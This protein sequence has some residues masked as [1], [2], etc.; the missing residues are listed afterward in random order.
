MRLLVLSDIHNN[1]ACVRKLRD[2]ETNRFDAVVIAGD[3]GSREA[4]KI[5]AVLETFACPVYYVFGNW[6]STLDYDRSF[7]P[8]AF[9]LHHRVFRQ[10]GLNFTGFSGCRARWGKN[11]IAAK[12]TEEVRRAFPA[13]PG[14]GMRPVQI[15][16][17]HKA[18]R[19]V[20]EEA[21]RRNRKVLEDLIARSGA[22]VKDFIIVTH[23]RL[24]KLNESIGKPLLHIFGHH[25]APRHTVYKGVHYLNASVLDFPAGIYPVKVY[26][27]C[28]GNVDCIP[29]SDRGDANLGNYFVV[30]LS[31]FRV[32]TVEQIDLPLD[33][34]Q[35]VIAVNFDEPGT[36]RR[37]FGRLIPEEE[38]YYASPL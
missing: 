15:E 19:Q 10:E 13:L 37:R 28:K 31:R 5:F 21:A 22:E 3:I 12:L 23:E 32:D 7:A 25:H 6:D 11:P 38:R 27:A 4:D 18:V 24:Y 36:C 35:Y 9:H 1:L 30:T 20:S 34:R 14:A 26:E 16:R 29:V 8:H 33:G 2:T 17:Y